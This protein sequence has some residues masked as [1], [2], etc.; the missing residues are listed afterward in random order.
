MTQLIVAFAILRKRLKQKFFH[1]SG[2]ELMTVIFLDRQ[3]EIFENSI[4]VTGILVER[5]EPKFSSTETYSMTITAACFFFG[6]LEIC[7]ETKS[8]TTLIN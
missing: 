4:Q 3:S 2:R 8:S 5:P 1:G 6:I 7:H